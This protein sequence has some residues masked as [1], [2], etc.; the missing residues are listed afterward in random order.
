[1]SLRYTTQML[2]TKLLRALLIYAWKVAGA[3]VSLNGITVYSKCL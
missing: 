1:M 2:S 3:L